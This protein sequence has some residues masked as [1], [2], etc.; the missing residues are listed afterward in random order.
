MAEQVSVEDGVESLV[1][2]PRVS[3]T[4]SHDRLILASGGSLH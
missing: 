1:Q 4:E 3:I 2:M